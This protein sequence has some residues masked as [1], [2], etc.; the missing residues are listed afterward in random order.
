VV[1]VVAG[2]IQVHF[3]L[4]SFTKVLLKPYDEIFSVVIFSNFALNFSSDPE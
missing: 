4:E 2:Y 1:N 3:S